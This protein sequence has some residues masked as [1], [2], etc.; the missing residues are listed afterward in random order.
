MV[1]SNCTF[2]GTTSGIRIK[3]ARGRGGLVANLVYSDITMTNVDFPIYLT[4]YYPKVPSEDVIQ[5]M[6]SATPIYRN[7][8]IRNLTASGSRVAGEIVGL[9]ESPISDLVLDNIHI[10][11]PKGMTLRNARGIGFE[12]STINVQSGSPLILETN[13]VVT[14]F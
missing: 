3:S 9:P 11:A 5:P 14:G 12:N 13:A 2:N 6:S 1:V 8:Q 4:S 10:K 7:I